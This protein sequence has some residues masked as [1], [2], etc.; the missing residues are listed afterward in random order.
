MFRFLYQVGL[1]FLDDRKASCPT[2]SNVKRVGFPYPITG[3]IPKVADHELR[4][5]THID[6]A[7]IGGHLRE[8][9]RQMACCRG[10]EG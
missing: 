7:V 5:E 4:L 10:Q 9:S 2:L 8:L 6:D 3:Y 1:Q